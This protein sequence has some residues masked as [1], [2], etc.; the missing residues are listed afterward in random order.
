MTEPDTGR[1]WRTRLGS[2]MFVLLVACGSPVAPAPSSS[3]PVVGKSRLIDVGGY[4]LSLTCLGTSDPTVVI[5]SGAGLGGGDWFLVQL[6]LG[7]FPVRVC[8]YDRAG[9]GESDA[10]PG[11]PATSGSMA[12]ELHTLLSKAGLSPPY[13][14]VGHSMGGANMRMFAHDHPDEVVGM[15]LVD[16]A[17]WGLPGAPASMPGS[18]SDEFKEG[19]SV[20]DMRRSVAQLSHVESVGDI[21]LVVISHGHG[22]FPP[23]FEEAWTRAQDDLAAFSTESVH[24]VATRAGHLIEYDQ[25]DVV[26]EAIKQ[27][28]TAVREATPL[29]P[30]EASFP[31]L[32]AECRA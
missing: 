20:I 8:T 27:V 16:A 2:V 28:V 25:P 6:S 11:G 18:G 15:V 17:G 31:A 3:A 23:R 4:S 32:G 29:P 12:E 14:L 1:R 24:V 21:P 7:E 22:I 13:V 19:S 30:C 26:A 9:L 5:D 10:R